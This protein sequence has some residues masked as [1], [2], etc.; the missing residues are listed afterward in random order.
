MDNNT[1]P[2]HDELYQTQEN[3]QSI[4][5]DPATRRIILQKK[6]DYY[7]LQV[8]R[9]LKEHPCV[10][11]PE[12]LDYYESDG[13]LVVREEYIQ[14]KTLA[15]ILS[16]NEMD[17]QEKKAVVLSVMDGLIFLHHADPPV[18][19]R[20]LKA[21]NIL[22]AYDGSVKIIDY[23]AAKIYKPDA[24]RDTVLIGTQGSAAPEQYG[25][26]ASD[27]RTDIYALGILIREL[28]PDDRKL[29]AIADRAAMLDPSD[30]YQTVEAMRRD[31]AAEQIAAYRK[32]LPPGFRTGKPWKM[33]IAIP[34]YLFIL[35][36]C[37]KME[38]TD[39]VTGEVIHG[40]DLWKYRIITTLI[41]FCWLDLFTGWSHLY[42]RFPFIKSRNILLKIIGYALAAF[43]I[44]AVFTLI[45][46]LIL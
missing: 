17:R 15:E 35:Y 39:S 40:A 4:L 1:G 16:E 8:F 41:L 2:V 20:D 44:L 3:R 38:I 21:S 7:D 36:I 34:V 27:T 10:Y 12:I 32:Y 30:R 13:K 37:F 28:F 43:L 6:L 14:G 25:F 9:Y 26:G 33:I 42:D 46:G 24:A 45:L 31:F 18:I 5:I 23:D 19:H 29:L 22:V 11:I